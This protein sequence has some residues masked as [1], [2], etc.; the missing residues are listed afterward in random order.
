MKPLFLSLMSM[1]FLTVAGHS[2]AD[3]KRI[4]Q[5]YIF[6][7]SARTDSTDT[8]RTKET[9]YLDVA[10]DGSS[11]F[12][13]M[14]QLFGDSMRRAFASGSG[15]Q[16]MTDG[17]RGGTENR[18]VMG[19]PARGAGGGGGR[20]MMGMRS[21]SPYIITR[22]GGTEI[23][24]RENAGMENYYYTEDLSNINWTMLEG[25]HDYHGM[26]AQKATAEYGGRTWFALFSFDIPLMDGP[27][28]FKTLPGFVVKAWDSNEHYVFSFIESQKV[29]TD[30]S[31]ELPGNAQK[32][33]KSQLA[34]AIY[35][36]RSRPIA[37]NF[38]QG[39]NVRIQM[40]DQDGREIT[41]EDIEKRRRDQL[42]K[43]NNPIE[44]IK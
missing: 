19:G 25:I 10:E 15:R 21:V 23:T 31:L 3:G 28:K 44:F 14:G 35:N 7:L 43:E 18:V 2:Q 32:A 24:Y 40:R 39:A 26:K 17:G 29:E 12:A 13:G 1:L 42:K 11:R 30:Y 34:K 6:E 33:T 38:P 5:R 9:L 37:T 20:G 16:M 4:I 41:M 8:A 27:Y 22:T 36:F